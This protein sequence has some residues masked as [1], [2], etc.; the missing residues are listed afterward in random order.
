[1]HLNL[2]QA[3]RQ[4]AYT[5]ED[6]HPGLEPRMLR[7][8]RRVM[9]ISPIRITCH[10]IHCATKRYSIA[11]LRMVFVRGNLP[12]THCALT[13]GLEPTSPKLTTW[14]STVEIRKLRRDRKIRP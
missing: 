14:S 7:S 4:M 11:G 1:M 10:S 5:S 13:M 3:A 6:P 2:N 9:P 8:E 12:S